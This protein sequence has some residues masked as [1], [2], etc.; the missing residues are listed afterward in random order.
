MLP[1][2][3]RRVRI[4]IGLQ[5][6]SSEGSAERQLAIA[7]DAEKILQE[8]VELIPTLED[9]VLRYRRE[10]VTL[11]QATFVRR[12]AVMR[13]GGTWVTDDP[14]DCDMFNLNR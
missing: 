10:V 9:A 12:G 8:Y 4:D 14:L 11:Q 1:G 6:P 2:A 5:W 3:F 13:I 7:V